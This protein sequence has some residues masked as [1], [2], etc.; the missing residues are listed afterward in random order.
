MAVCKS[1]PPLGTVPCG[2][3]RYNGDD[4]KAGSYYMEVHMKALSDDMVH[5][6]AAVKV[7]IINCNNSTSY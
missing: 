3:V 1:G 7:K 5:S 4:H 2:K 6:F